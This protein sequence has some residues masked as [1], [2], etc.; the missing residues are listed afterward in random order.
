VNEPA[1]VLAQKAVHEALQGYLQD[2]E[3]AVHWTLTIDV[4]AQDDVR[5]LAHRAGGG[6][7]G[8]DMPTA[9]A[10]AGMLQA[11]SDV[12]RRQL[13]AMTGPVEDEDDE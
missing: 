5:Y 13:E 3:I 6:V 8:T 7:D 4:A 1:H 11:S 12:A 2:G 9:W 10:A